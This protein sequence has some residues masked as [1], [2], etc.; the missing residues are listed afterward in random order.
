[1]LFASETRSFLFCEYA[2]N[3][4]ASNLGYLAPL[5]QFL[6]EIFHWDPFNAKRSCPQ[7]QLVWAM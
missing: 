7:N 6:M 2:R 1:M 5:G 3:T 4:L